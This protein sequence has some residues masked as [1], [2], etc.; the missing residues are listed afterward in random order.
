M[1]FPNLTGFLDRAKQHRHVALWRDLPADLETPVSAYLKLKKYGARFLLESV[2]GS[3]IIG[4]YSFIGVDEFETIAVRGRRVEIRSP[5]AENRALRE[6]ETPLDVVE[7]RL[8]RLD[9]CPEEALPSFF[10]GAVGYFGY[11]LVRHIERLPNRPPDELGAPDLFVAIS[12][13]LVIFD[14]FRRSCRVVTIA[15]TAEDPELAY[16]AALR[17]LDEL[18]RTLREGLPAGAADVES[19]AIGEPTSSMDSDIYVAAVER[20]K[21]Y[22]RDGDSFQVV[23]SRRVS[24]PSAVDPFALYRALRILTPSPYLFYL[25]FEELALVGAS[26][27]MLVKLDG[28]ICTTRPIAGTRPRGDTPAADRR[29]ARELLAD[30]K[31]RAEHVMLVD[32]GRNDL[33]RVSRFGTVRVTRMMEVEQFSHVMHIVSDVQGTAEKGRDAFDLLR[34]AFPAGTV[35][36]SPKVRAMEII[37]ELETT[38]RGPYAGAIGYIS[39]HG[40]IDTC[41]AIRT[42]LVTGGIVHLQAGAGIVADSDPHSEFEE[43]EAKLSAAMHAL[44]LAAGG[45]EH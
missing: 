15:D 2:E 22:I 7:E 4:R 8:A 19:T 5:H 23:L 31:E 38:S 17:R 20:I 10:G 35:S 41:I 25:D 13:T 3:E 32:L 29:L 30:P 33:G 26:P 14:H 24:I 16:R 18:C 9:V 21:E 6:G 43:T 1:I 11:D 27:E 12:R 45:L 42:A 36:G 37:D 34:A 39:F 40:N 44:K 28:R